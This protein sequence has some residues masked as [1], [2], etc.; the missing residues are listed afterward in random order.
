MMFQPSARDRR[1]ASIRNQ[2]ISRG[3]RISL[4]SGQAQGFT[5]YS[6]PW[7]CK[8]NDRNFWR[9]MRK[10]Y[11]H[12]VHLAEVWSVESASEPDASERE[13]LAQQ[14]PEL[15]SSVGFVESAPDGVALFW[16]EPAG[17]GELE[18]VLQWLQ[19]A[20]GR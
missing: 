13:W 14:L 6:M 5:R 7:Q 9:L 2:A 18:P 15:P 8:R 1:L 20:S 11:T 17:K 19:S 10:P 16:S 12:P 4:G 3:A